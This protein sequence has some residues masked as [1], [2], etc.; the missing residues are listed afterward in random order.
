MRTT[1]RWTAVC[2]L[3]LSVVAHAAQNAPLVD[4]FAWRGSLALP[5]GSSLARVELPVEALMRM[6]S[7]TGSDVR[8]FNADGAVVPFALLRPMDTASSAPAV[9]T[10]SYQAYA[11]YGGEAGAP[12]VRGAV[13]VKVG[14]DGSAGSAWVHWGAA[15]ANKGAAGL[16]AQPGA[17]PGPVDGDRRPHRRP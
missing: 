10:R 12:P 1:L 11:L 3:A 14:T 9:Q 8:V 7:A 2:A 6:Q 16:P 15:A 5:Q 4:E 17:Q 13:E